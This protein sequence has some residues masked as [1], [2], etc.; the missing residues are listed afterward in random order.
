MT[1][2]VTAPVAS[3]RV[4]VVVLHL[5]VASV[6]VVVAGSPVESGVFVGKGLSY[7]GQGW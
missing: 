1:A 6:V 2:A 5:A 4:V 7:S 3:L